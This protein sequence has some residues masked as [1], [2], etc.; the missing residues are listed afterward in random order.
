MD[1]DAVDMTA[2]PPYMKSMIDSVRN[3]VATGLAGSASSTPK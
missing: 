2:I 3:D 1:L